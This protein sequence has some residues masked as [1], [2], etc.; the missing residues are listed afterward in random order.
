MIVC[1]GDSSL[2]ISKVDVDDVKNERRRGRERAARVGGLA[3]GDPAR[4]DG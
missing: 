4:T 2:Q 3:S 1:E